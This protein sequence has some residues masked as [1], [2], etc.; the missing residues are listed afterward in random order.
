[1][2]IENSKIKKINLQEIKELVINVFQNQGCD[3]PNAN[4]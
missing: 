1:M 4:A 2:N 3:L